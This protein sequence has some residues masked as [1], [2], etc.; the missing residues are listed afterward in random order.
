[1]QET[2]VHFD[3]GL[4]ILVDTR[5]IYAVS[6]TEK[7]AQHPRLHPK[8]FWSAS[9]SASRAATRAWVF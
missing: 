7:S 9:I 5:W 4:G 6:M 3:D 8:V 2:N 1:V